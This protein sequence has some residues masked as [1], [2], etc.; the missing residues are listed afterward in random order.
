M[1]KVAVVHAG[2]AQVELDWAKQFAGL[3]AEV[4]K[5]FATVVQWVERSTTVHS[6]AN[7]T[8][9]D[10]VAAVSAAIKDAGTGGTVVVVSGHGGAVPGNVDR[11][12]IIWDPNAA[13]VGLTWTSGNFGNG[14][15]WDGDHI[16]YNT[17]SSGPSQKEVDEKNIADDTSPGKQDT[18]HKQKR[19]EAFL[20]LDQIRV[21]IAATKIRR[22]T[23]TSCTVG[24]A[25]GFIDGLAKFLKTEVAAFNQETSVIDDTQYKPSVQGKSRLILFADNSADGKGT[26]VMLARANSPNLDDP[27]I[28]HVGRP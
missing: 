17:S 7:V 10:T 9:T 27:K 6:I 19:L 1:K 15:F 11:G 20:A 28:A 4:K 21:A 26:N 18:L 23:F 5:Q 12:I 22:L 2:A 25:T 13:T 14:M 16:G 8:W 3:D 24:A